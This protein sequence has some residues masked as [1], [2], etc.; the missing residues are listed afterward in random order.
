[1]ISAACISAKSFLWAPVNFVGKEKKMASIK[2][3]GKKLVVVFVNRHRVRKTR[4]QRLRNFEK[5]KFL[6]IIKKSSR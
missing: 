2:S 1:M 5:F 6:E 4:F 3:T